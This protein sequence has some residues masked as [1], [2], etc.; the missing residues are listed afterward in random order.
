MQDRNGRIQVA[1]PADK[2]KQWNEARHTNKYT[3]ET[4]DNLISRYEE[5]SAFVRWDSPLFTI[6]WSDDELPTEDI[7]NAI[8]KGELRPP[9]QATVAAATGT[10]D[11][12]QVLESTV[13]SVITAV[14]AAQSTLPG[15]G[16]TTLTVPLSG[17]PSSTRVSLTLPHRTM[18]MPQLQRVGRQFVTLKKQAGSRN[19]IKAETIA[20]LFAKYIEDST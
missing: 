15:G 8:V 12:L 20:E 14:L 5:P 6:P 7:Y 16:H 1:A 3:P 10:T 11:Y 13:S 19:E 17:S 2:C 18:T 9:T 4:L